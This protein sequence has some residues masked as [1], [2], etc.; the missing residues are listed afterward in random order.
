MKKSIPILFAIALSLLYIGYIEPS[1][2]EPIPDWIR[3][4]ALWWG[5]GKISDT[6]FI[7]AMQWLFDNE[8]LSMTEKNELKNT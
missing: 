5:E 3:E 7:N 2:G 1:H 8:I 6:E 4:T